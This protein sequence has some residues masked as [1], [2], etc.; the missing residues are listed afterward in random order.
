[1]EEVEDWM[2]ERYKEEVPFVVLGDFNRRFSDRDDAW[3]DLN[4]KKPTGFEIEAPTISRRAKCRDGRY[5][6]FID[7]IVMSDSLARRMVPDSFQQWNYRTWDP[8]V[9]SDHCPIGVNLR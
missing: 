3:A 1:L 2:E 9:L 6:K 8:P 5:S 7:H 4:D